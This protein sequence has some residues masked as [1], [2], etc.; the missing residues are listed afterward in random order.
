MPKEQDYGMIM[1]NPLIRNFLFSLYDSKTRASFLSEADYHLGK[2]F[3][4]LLEDKGLI[5]YVAEPHVRYCRLRQ[6]GIDLIERGLPPK[7][8]AKD[9]MKHRAKH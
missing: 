1:A 7:I 6:K 8:T 4:G 2:N 9:I 3:F 5:Q